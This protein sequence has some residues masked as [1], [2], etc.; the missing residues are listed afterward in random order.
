MQEVKDSEEESEPTSDPDGSPRAAPGQ[1]APPPENPKEDDLQEDPPEG[2]SEGNGP[3]PTVRN[4]G[5]EEE[6]V[7]VQANVC[8]TRVKHA[9][10]QRKAQQLRARRG[11]CRAVLGCVA[12]T[13]GKFLRRI[14]C[15]DSLK[16]WIERSIE[17]RGFGANSRTK[18]KKTKNFHD[19]CIRRKRGKRTGAVRLV[20][21]IRIGSQSSKFTFEQT[22]V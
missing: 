13:L 1:N 3:R 20:G 22:A 18:A 11:T 6:T 15:L 14:F 12:G 10:K 4:D 21:P 17:K 19:K 9:I 5:R 16:N 2:T 8:A 7:A